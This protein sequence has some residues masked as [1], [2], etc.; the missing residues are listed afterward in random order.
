METGFRT[1]N[2]A[3]HLL[4]LTTIFVSLILFF[5][6]ELFQKCYVRHQFLADSS[7]RARFAQMGIAGVITK[8]FEPTS[9][10]EEVTHILGWDD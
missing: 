4:P 5:T 2:S 1:E 6:L 9:I 8:P 7:D 10:C 3:V